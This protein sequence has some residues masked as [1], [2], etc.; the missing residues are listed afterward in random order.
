MIPRVCILCDAV[1]TPKP[2]DGD[3]Q[4]ACPKC[5]E[6]YAG[7]AALDKLAKREGLIDDVLSA[8]KGGES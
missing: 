3:Y 4:D 6:K 8:N 5:R 7:D 2:S 1:W